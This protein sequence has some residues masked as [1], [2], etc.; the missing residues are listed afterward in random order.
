MVD[1]SIRL[2]SVY[3]SPF[4]KEAVMKHR[5]REVPSEVGEIIDRGQGQ[6]YSIVGHSMAP[7]ILDGDDVLVEWRVP[8]P[9][10][11]VVLSRAATDRDGTACVTGGQFMMVAV[12][13]RDRTFGKMNRV[14]SDGATAGWRVRGVVTRIFHRVSNPGTP[15]PHERSDMKLLKE[16]GIVF[17][18]DFGFLGEEDVESL[19]KALAIPRSEFTEGGNLPKAMF[20]C[21]SRVLGE[22]VRAGDQLVVEPR[23]GDIPQSEIVIATNGATIE[24]CRCR[25]AKGRV[26]GRIV[27]VNGAEPGGA[28]GSGDRGL[29][30]Q[31]SLMLV[32]G[33]PHP[34]GAA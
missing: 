34:G 5:T 27:R 9:G 19:S 11:L 30:P 25:D 2:N 31:G 12:W 32:G 23:Y 20:R 18:R 13:K 4:S 33:G 26:F 10:E 24:I 7:R 1:E 14:F 21:S 3:H 22:G 28:D 16:L 17:D 29:P 8:L 15:T 6:L